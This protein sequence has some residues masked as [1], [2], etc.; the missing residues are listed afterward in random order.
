MAE[1]ASGP[2]PL[3]TRVGP[4]SYLAP[5]DDRGLAVLTGGFVLSLARVAKAF[6]TLPARTV[7]KR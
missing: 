7:E 2:S 3:S 5:P 6:W 1:A 4:M